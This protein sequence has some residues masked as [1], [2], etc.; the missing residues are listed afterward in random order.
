MGNQ[1]NGMTG[2]GR[3]E[4]GEIWKQYR[5]KDQKNGKIRKSEM[6]MILFIF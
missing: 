5:F 6:N 4:T 3:R 2:D 1:K